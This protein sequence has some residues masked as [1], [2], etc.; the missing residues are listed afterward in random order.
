MTNRASCWAE[1][2]KREPC[3][4]PVPAVPAKELLPRPQN[5][6]H[7]VESGKWGFPP[8]TPDQMLYARGL[9]DR[10]YSVVLRCVM[11]Y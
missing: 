7:S 4:K 1:P 10:E 9:V 6:V 5:G 3:T 11:Q 2:I 8:V